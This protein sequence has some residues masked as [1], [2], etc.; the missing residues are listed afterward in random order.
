M[1][2]KRFGDDISHYDPAVNLQLNSAPMWQQYPLR[3]EKHK[4]INM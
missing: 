2:S 4:C 3:S 1:C